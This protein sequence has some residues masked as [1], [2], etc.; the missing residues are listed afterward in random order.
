M[1]EEIG[2]TVTYQI[3]IGLFGGYASFPITLRADAAG[4]GRSI[5]NKKVL[6]TYAITRA[7]VSH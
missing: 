4:K 3:N 7:M 5:G 1:N 2:V 6:K